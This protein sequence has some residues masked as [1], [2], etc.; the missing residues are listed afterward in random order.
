MIGLCKAQCLIPG[1]QTKQNYL[2]KGRQDLH[3]VVGEAGPVGCS[4]SLDLKL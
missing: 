4:Y 2:I 3:F 1:P